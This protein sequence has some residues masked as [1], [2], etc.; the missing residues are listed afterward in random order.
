MN[1]QNT[2]PARRPR[3]EELI[4]ANMKVV[5]SQAANKHIALKGIE[6]I[7]L[8]APPGHGT[9]TVVCPSRSPVLDPV[10]WILTVVPRITDDVKIS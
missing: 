10:I 5:M 1:G 8:Y 3:R 4:L 2:Y 7:S 9:L 6:P